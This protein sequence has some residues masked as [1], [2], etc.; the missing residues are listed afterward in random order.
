MQQSLFLAVGL[1]FIL[2]GVLPFLLPHFWRQMMQQISNQTD[3]GIRIFGLVS[4]LI[5][6]III[7]FIKN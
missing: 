2:E 1:V 6:L 3:R 4:M 5:G 7:Y